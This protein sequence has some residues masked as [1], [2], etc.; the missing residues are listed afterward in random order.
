MGGL[1]GARSPP[2]QMARVL[3]LIVGGLS[4]GGVYAL[5]AFAMSLTISTTRVLNVAHGVFFVWG[6]A[7]FVVLSQRLSLHPALALVALVALFLVLALLFQ[8]G[9]VRTLLGRSVVATSVGSEAHEI[10]I[11]MI[12]DLLEQAGHPYR[13]ESR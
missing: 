4:L 5:L 1:E 12:A 2:R 13:F 9:I 3:E 10:G 6:G 8:W 7:T 11:R